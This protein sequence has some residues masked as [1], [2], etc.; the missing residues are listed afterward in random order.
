MIKNVGFNQSNI[1]ILLYF[2]FSNLIEYFKNILYNQNKDAVGRKYQ[3]LHENLLIYFPN[4]ANLEKT[5]SDLKL[6]INKV[7]RN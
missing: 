3:K 1:M 7:Q 6:T 4:K 2:S 5:I